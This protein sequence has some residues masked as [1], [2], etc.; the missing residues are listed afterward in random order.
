MS[1]EIYHWAQSLMSQ[2][3]ETKKEAERLLYQEYECQRN[4]IEEKR[5]EYIQKA[6]IYQKNNDKEQMEQLITQC[7]TLK[8]ELAAL[9]YSTHRI[10]YLTLVSHD[11][12]NHERLQSTSIDGHKNEMHTTESF[13]PRNTEQKRSVCTTIYY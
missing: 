7:N 2:I 13:P 4:Y 8:F 9:E 12:L 5:R 3:E 11:N 6:L 10:R 1:N